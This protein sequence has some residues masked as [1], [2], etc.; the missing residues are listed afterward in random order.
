MHRADLL[1]AVAFYCHR[2]HRHRHRRGGGGG[3]GGG[4][5][6]GGCSFGGHV[7]LG[8]AGTLARAACAWRAQAQLQLE[9]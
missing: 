3:G 5:S 6:G 4:G 8:G 1:A 2:C 7:A 9:G